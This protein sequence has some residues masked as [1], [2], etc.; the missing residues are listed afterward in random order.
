MTLLLNLVWAYAG[1]CEAGRVG[2][3]HARYYLPLLPCLGLAAAAGVRRLAVGPW[4]AG[5]LTALLVLL[6]ASVTVRYLALF[7]G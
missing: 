4:L 6:D 5:L 2:G 3:I 1:Y 7:P